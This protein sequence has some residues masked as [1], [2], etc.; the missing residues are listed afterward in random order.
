MSSQR[1]TSQKKK[2]VFS[3]FVKVRLMLPTTWEVFFKAYWEQKSFPLYIE[4][5]AILAKV[6]PLAMCPNK[7]HQSSEFTGILQ[8]TFS[9]AQEKT[10]EKLPLAHGIN[11]E[12]RYEANGLACY[13][14]S[15]KIIQP[16]QLADLR[17]DLMAFNNYLSERVE[18]GELD[19]HCLEASQQNLGHLDALHFDQCDSPFLKKDTTFW[20]GHWSAIDTLS[21]SSSALSSQKRAK[22]TSNEPTDM[23]QVAP[24]AKSAVTS[25]EPTPSGNAFF[26]RGN[27]YS[28]EDA[29]QVVVFLRVIHRTHLTWGGLFCPR[30]SDL[31][32]CLG[33][34]SVPYAMETRIAD[35]KKIAAHYQQLKAALDEF[36]STHSDLNDLGIQFKLLLWHEYEYKLDGET[37][38]FSD[39]ATSTL[40]AIPDVTMRSH[41]MNCQNYHFYNPSSSTVCYYTYTEAF[42]D[43]GDDLFSSI[44]LQL[45]QGSNSTIT[46]NPKKRN[47]KILGFSL[48]IGDKD[49]AIFTRVNEEDPYRFQTDAPIA[50]DTL[51]ALSGSGWYLKVNLADCPDKDCPRYSMDEEEKVLHCNPQI[52][53]ISSASANQYILFIDVGSTRVKF[54]EAQVEKNKISKLK[55]KL[56][57]STENFLNTYNLNEILTENDITTTAQ[58]KHALITD[59]AL[60][61]T[62]FTSLTRE[63][64]AHLQKEGRLLHS[65]YCCFPTVNREKD[66]SFLEQRSEAIDRD[67]GPF[68]CA[69]KGKRFILTAEHLALCNMFKPLLTKLVAPVVKEIS[70]KCEALQEEA[71]AQLDVAKQADQRWFFEKWLYGRTDEVIQKTR[72]LDD[73]KGNVYHVR[74]SD[75]YK[76]IYKLNEVGSALAKFKNT[77]LLDGG[78]YSLDAYCVDS[79]G[80]RFLPLT[81][82]F[83]CGGEA[84]V[85]RY[86]EELKK[87]RDVEIGIVR[88]NIFNDNLTNLALFKEKL[89]EIYREPI[90][91]IKDDDFPLGCT[92][93]ILILSGQVFKNQHL[94]DLFKDANY[95]DVVLSTQR[96]YE[97]LAFFFEENGGA[98]I[99]W[100][101]S[102]DLCKQW[103]IFKTIALT[104]GSKPHPSADYDLVGGMLQNAIN[105]VELKGASYDKAFFKRFW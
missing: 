101:P 99:G 27:Y 52:D 23:P 8:L 72:Q 97:A 84:L 1:T 26:E 53:A 79:K 100:K 54:V 41:L 77:L 78:G 37:I 83:K 7:N 22:L 76:F 62:F 82:S 65:V 96:L 57:M 98:P 59:E 45:N 35:E 15:C 60:F 92:D 104:Q 11:L 90:D 24:Q 93:S 39:G 40:S 103:N 42:H 91:C 74:Y 43:E 49:K 105:N 70:K 71:K 46:A 18:R 51:L 21:I 55:S 2:R 28:F 25:S 85:N 102:Q 88:T 94:A 6:L 36:C 4:G 80:E 48:K 64:S 47:L 5:E 30:F 34:L 38:A 10:I 61:E 63:Y 32:Q 16:T 19:N 73:V 75:A 81:G 66:E 14:C 56:V 68:V 58:L 20:C 50:L 13:A 33:S 95:F 86:Y 9:S 17:N 29:N 67:I 69:P 12:R 87:T 44:L 89:N 3:A 31:E